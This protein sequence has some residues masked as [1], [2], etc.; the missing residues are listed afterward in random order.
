M[1]GQIKWLLTSPQGTQSEVLPGRYLNIHR[2]INV[3]AV[4]V[5]FWGENPRGVWTLMANINDDNHNGNILFFV[6]INE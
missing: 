5:Q 2:Q 6:C 3:T 1:G 4:S